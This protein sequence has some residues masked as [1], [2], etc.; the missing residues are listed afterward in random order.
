MNILVVGCAGY[1]GSHMVSVLMERGHQVVVLDNLS[2]GHRD[3]VLAGHFVPADLADSAEVDAIFN[4]NRFDAVMHFASSSQVGE[5]MQNP[6]LYYRN[7]VSNTLNLLDAMVKHKVRH[8]IFSSSAAVFGEPESVPIAESHPMQ[9]INPYGKT[10]SMVESI[11][12]DY[13]SAHGLKSI[14]LRYFNAAG[15]HPGAILGE[16][17]DPETHLIPLVLQAANGQRNYIQIFGS[18]YD[19]EDGT[20]VRDYIHIMDLCEAHLLAL[21]KLRRD[22]QSKAYNL[23][24]GQGY[25]VKQVITAASRVVGHAIPVRYAPRRAGD[26]ARLTADASLALKELGWQPRYPQLETIIEHAWRWHCQIHPAQVFPRCSVSA[27]KPL[28]QNAGKHEAVLDA[29]PNVG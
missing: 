22:E 17:H 3:A 23:G 2:T 27:G 5:S 11:L 7:N 15:A 14:C 12:A 6:G 20:C 9:P 28:R 10:K 24:N 18:D 4:A 25:S 8:F 21:E 26:P 13:D 16:R 1:I 29:I 19:T